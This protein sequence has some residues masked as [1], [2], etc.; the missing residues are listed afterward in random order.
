M[1]PLN[2]SK[3]QIPGRQSERQRYKIR[4]LD[5]KTGNN[6]VRHGEILL[7]ENDGKLL[8][9]TRQSGTATQG[10]TGYIH[11]RGGITRHR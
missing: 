3:G 5:S 7:H 1:S 10:S 4:R 2:Q 8:Y 11:R 9:E 6:T